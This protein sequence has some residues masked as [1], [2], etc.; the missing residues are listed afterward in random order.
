[1]C[2]GA[3]SSATSPRSIIIG[4]IERT[5]AFASDL[6]FHIQAH[7][8][9]EASGLCDNQDVRFTVQEVTCL[10]QVLFLEKKPGD[11]GLLTVAPLESGVA[12]CTESDVVSVLAQSLATIRPV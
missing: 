12:K 6:P 9:Q 5:V 3:L 10:F 4:V 1:V 7:L 8:P 11:L 2:V